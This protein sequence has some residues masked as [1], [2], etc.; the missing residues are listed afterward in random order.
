MPLEDFEKKIIALYEF[1]IAK[2][3]CDIINKNS[4]FLETLLKRQLQSGLDA[5]GKPKT[6]IREG[7]AFPFYAD[8]TYEQ[9][10][11]F[12]SGLG[13][14]TDR[15]THYMT[16]AFYSTLKVHA[17][18]QEFAFDSSVSHFKDILSSSGSGSRIIELSDENLRIFSEKILIPQ[19]QQR[20]K[21]AFNGI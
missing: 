13:K 3:A 12:G 15:I 1:D 5:D 16:G 7:E 10:R 19:I 8:Y 4:K 11:E 21:E 2:E 9:K 6:L 14:A 17:S 18:G 20:F